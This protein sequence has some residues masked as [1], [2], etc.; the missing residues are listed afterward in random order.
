MKLEIQEAAARRDAEASFMRGRRSLRQAVGHALT[1]SLEALGGRLG[2]G[3]WFA[4]EA[5]LEST[6]PHVNRLRE[7]LDRDRAIIAANP[8]LLELE[9]ARSPARAVPPPLPA[10]APMAKPP[11]PPAT[12]QEPIRTRTMAKLL[13]SQGH[14]ERALSI[15]D[16][17]L[18][19]PGADNTLRAEAEALRSS[20]G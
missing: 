7:V 9:P 13:A 20:V 3:S 6:R 17:L 5:G 4:K 8:E 19:R 2:G 14:P 1:G 12:C 18:A 15:Y 10:P 11:A 16:Y